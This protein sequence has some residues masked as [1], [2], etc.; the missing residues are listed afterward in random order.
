M[1]LTTLT[2]QTLV[3]WSLTECP[4]EACG[5]LTAHDLCLTENCAPDTTIAF[6]CHGV[7][8]VK[9]FA[10]GLLVKGDFRGYAIWHSHPKSRATPTPPD[11]ALMQATLVPMIIV[12]LVQRVPDISVY[13]L[14]GH[15]S[16]RA[17]LLR[18]YRPLPSPVM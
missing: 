1:E 12:G 7:G 14:D 11:L 8:K 18:T 15:N 5:Y 10:P 3:A 13:V 2:Q 9:L 16:E 6:V 4:N 17:I